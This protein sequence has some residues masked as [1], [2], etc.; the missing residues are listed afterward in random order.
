MKFLAFV[1]RVYSFAFHLTLG[2]FLLALAY[3]AFQ[4]HQ[5]LRL[6]MLPFDD[7]YL[8]RDIALFG[9]AGVLCTLLTLTRWFRFVFVI[10]TLLA[11]YVMLKGFFFGPHALR[12]PHQMRA[13]AWLTFGAL[14]AFVGAAWSLKTRG[15][16]GFL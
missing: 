13:A 3:I 2:V 16:A 6:G 8:M 4:S 11:F 1:L 10:W 12:A 14:A 9:I 15:R 5:P 7:E